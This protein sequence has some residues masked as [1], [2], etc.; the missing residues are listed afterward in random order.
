M[1]GKLMSEN[2]SENESYTDMCDKY[3]GPK[4]YLHINN[5]AAELENSAVIQIK[6][7]S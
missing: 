3:P 6:K 5:I 1:S 4:G 7:K 2:R